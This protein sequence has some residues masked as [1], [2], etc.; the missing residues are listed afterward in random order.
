VDSGDVRYSIEE[1]VEG[2]PFDCIACEE[3]EVDIDEEDV[4]TEE[5]DEIWGESIVEIL[6]ESIV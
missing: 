2:D 3:E 5:E 6:G 1:W 4:D